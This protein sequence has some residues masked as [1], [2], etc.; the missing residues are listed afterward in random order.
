MH[1]AET[2]VPA[3]MN[4]KLEIFVYIKSYKMQN[5]HTNEKTRIGKERNGKDCMEIYKSDYRKMLQSECQ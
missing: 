4:L 2:S 3:S 5:T 1:V